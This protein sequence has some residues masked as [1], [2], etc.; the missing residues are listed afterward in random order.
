[1]S[2]EFPITYKYEID[3]SADVRLAR[4]GLLKH[5]ARQK[6]I[7]LDE[8]RGIVSMLAKSLEDK[9]LNVRQQVAKWLPEFKAEDLSEPTI[10]LLKK[11]RKEKGR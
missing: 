2:E 1:M 11:Y 8:R 4:C 5:L 7:T 10:K 6:S 9:D 3:W